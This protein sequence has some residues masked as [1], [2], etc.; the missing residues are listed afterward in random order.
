M[1]W[2]IAANLSMLFT[3]VPLAERIE[4][5]ASAGFDG[6]EIQF[7]YELPA[8][9]LKSRLESARMPLVLINLPAADLLQGGPGLAAVPGR[10]AEF[11]Q[12][13]EQGLAYA[14]Q[15]RPQRINVLP[16]RLVEGLSR[17]AA[18]ETLAERLQRAA[19]AFATIGVGV[20]CEAINRHDMP[21]FLLSTSAELLVMLERVGHANLSAQLDLYHMARMD[22]VL[23]D[24]IERLAGRIGHVQFADSPGRA[25][26]G[27]GVLDF[28]GALAALKRAG[29]QGWLAAE[30]RPASSTAASLGWLARWR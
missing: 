29:Y 2:P 1:P 13:L 17:E 3:E 28:A 21:G 26:P 22:E 24:S 18:L 30:Y 10:A 23:T 15:V 7:P 14:E 20:T 11:E 6:V 25:E 12:A 8:P 9:E 19:Q 5:A 27:T 16:G 4:A